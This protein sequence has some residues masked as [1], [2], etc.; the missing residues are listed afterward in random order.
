[1]AEPRWT[2]TRSDDAVLEIRTDVTGKA[3]AVG[4]RL[5]I[6]VTR[7]QAVVKW[8]GDQPSAAE[9]TAELDSI[10]VV[11][12]EGGLT[13]LIGPEKLVARANALRTLDAKNHPEVVFD[14]GT[15][16]STDSGYRL[17]G[18]LTIHGVTRDH[19]VDLS[20]TTEA[21]RHHLS[22]ESVLRQSDFD[23]KPYSQLLGAMKVVDEVIVAFRA[24]VP[25]KG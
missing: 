5:T 19:A 23:V 16:E 18:T 13:P 8:D 1:M 14:A 20:L 11:R 24:I 17:S 10:E 15:I 7:W 3:A 12:G 2:L 4:H 25:G 6:E 9:L 22:T 21:G